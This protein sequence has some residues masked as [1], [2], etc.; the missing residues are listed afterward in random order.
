MQNITDDFIWES[1]GRGLMAYKKL[2]KREIGS[3]WKDLGSGERRNV[4]SC[5]N[6]MEEVAK[7]PKKFLSKESTE[8]IWLERAKRYAIA[9]NLSL[10]NKNA[11]MGFVMSPAYDV[12]NMCVDALNQSLG[13][14]YLNFLEHIQNYSYSSVENRVVN[15]QEVVKLS[16]RICKIADIQES[17]IIIKRLKMLKVFIE[18][19]Y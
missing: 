17:G 9:N 7:N 5:L 14:A 19:H 6:N 4:A 1:A 10:E 8:S 13:Y 15:G 3:I 11:G 18:R 16:N 12:W 2:A